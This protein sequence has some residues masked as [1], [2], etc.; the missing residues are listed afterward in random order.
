MSFVHTVPG[1]VRGGILRHAKGGVGISILI[2]IT[3]LL[4]P[5]INT[6]PMKC[7]EMHLFFVTSARYGSSQGAAAAAGV[8]LNGGMAVAK[9]SDGLMDS[10]MYSVDN[11][12][13]SAGPKVEKLLGEFRE[14]GTAEKV[15][16]YVAADF[17]RITGTEGGA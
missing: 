6:P 4:E 8:P 9:G 7:G 3:R 16:E 2:G 17:K 12:V 5:L 11:K 10:A 13:E 1:V 14:D 15:W